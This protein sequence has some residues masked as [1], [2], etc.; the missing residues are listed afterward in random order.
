[1]G[2]LKGFVGFIVTKYLKLFRAIA[3]RYNREAAEGLSLKSD[4]FVMRVIHVSRLL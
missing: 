4:D 3:T 1:M 2:R